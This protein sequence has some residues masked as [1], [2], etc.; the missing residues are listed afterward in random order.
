LY[1]IPRWFGVLYDIPSDFLVELRDL[2]FSNRL[3]IILLNLFMLF[4]KM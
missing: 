1:D 2:S 3:L 4:L